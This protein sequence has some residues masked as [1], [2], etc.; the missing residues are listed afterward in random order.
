MMRKIRRRWSTPH[1]LS[2]LALFFAIG[3]AT[4]A[5]L[6]KHSI[7][8]DD[9]APGAVDRNAIAKNAVNQ[10][11][12]SSRAR[13]R[14]GFTPVPSGK[15]IRGAVGGDFHVFAPSPGESFDFGTDV[16]LPHPA[17]NALG[18]NDVFVNVSHWQDGGSQLQPTTTDTNAGC[19]GTPTKPTAPKGKVCIYV[20]GS[21]NA[22]NL[23]GYSVLFGTGKSRYGFKLKWDAT[24]QGDTFVDATW[25]YRAP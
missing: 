1:V 20:S 22:V 14:L 6:P 5:A 25:A 11:R 12:I 15:T 8:S 16:T 2:A 4:A 13:Q 23:S 17:A 18:D 9:F 19:T 21:D 3:G 7:R 10:S 24:H